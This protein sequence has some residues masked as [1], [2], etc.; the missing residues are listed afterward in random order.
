MAEAQSGG[1]FPAQTGAKTAA[2]AKNYDAKIDRPCNIVG[3]SVYDSEEQLNGD[4]VLVSL[5]D[6][7]GETTFNFPSG[8]AGGDTVYCWTGS[9]PANHLWTVRVNVTGPTATTPVVGV[10]WR[11]RGQA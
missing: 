7:A 2:T 1:V 3:I 5:L 8:A 10:L 9:V 11:P 6:S 4:L